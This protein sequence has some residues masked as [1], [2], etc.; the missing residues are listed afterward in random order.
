M[1]DWLARVVAPLNTVVFHMGADAVTWAE[2]LGFIT[3]AICVYL[4]VRANV[5]N[6]W[7]GILNSALFLVLFATARLW[8]D[9]SLQ[10]TYIVL[11]FVGWWQWLHGGR[12][13]TALKIGRA[14]A[15][16]L[17]AC[18]A[19]VVL[20]TLVLTPVLRQAHDIA[21]LLDALTTSLSLAAQFLLNAKKI[22]NW[23]F[24]I[25]ADVIYTPLYLVKH[26]NLTGIV[27]VAFLG[28][29]ISGALRWRILAATTKAA[30][31]SRDAGERARAEAVA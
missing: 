7:T 12:D 29:A 17:L 10:F 26:L 13:R 1:L 3:G 24:W 6:F 27:Y 11:G 5:H 15:R 20:G 30:E 22:Q 14:S 8:A 4:V 21:P 16:M 9:A 23:L 19:F 18:I 25:A 2:L 28:L 31:G